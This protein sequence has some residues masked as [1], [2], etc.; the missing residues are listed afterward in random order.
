M[1]ARRACCLLAFL[2]QN[3]DKFVVVPVKEFDKAS[4]FLKK[5]YPTLSDSL[6]R[7]T[8]RDVP[9]DCKRLP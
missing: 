2:E 4:E 8:Y 5:H 3:G 7:G 9:T 6:M 1:S